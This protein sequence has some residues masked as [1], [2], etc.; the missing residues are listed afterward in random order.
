[1]DHTPIKLAV[2]NLDS[3][4]EAKGESMGNTSN[5]V[6]VKK[7][8]DGKIMMNESIENKMF[9]ENDNSNSY[10]RKKE[11]RIKKKMGGYARQAIDIKKQ[12]QSK[13]GDLG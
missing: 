5:G 9:D 11:V 13:I 7:L 2:K 1:M 12:E 3:I 4:D 6:Q 10:T 8:I